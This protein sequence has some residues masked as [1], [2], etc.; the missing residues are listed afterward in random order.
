MLEESRASQQNNGDDHDMNG[1][2]SSDDDRPS[3]VK[4]WVKTAL[5][6]GLFLQNSLGKRLKTK[7]KKF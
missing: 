3:T 6:H 2:G 4:G 1:S 5:Q 7:N